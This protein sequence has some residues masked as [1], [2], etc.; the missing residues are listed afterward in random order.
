M[1]A[2]LSTIAIEILI[3][4]HSPLSFQTHQTWW[5]INFFLV[6]LGVILAVHFLLLQLLNIFYG[7]YFCQ[8]MTLF[9][10]WFLWR[11]AGGWTGLCICCSGQLFCADISAAPA[12]LE[13][14]SLPLGNFTFFGLCLRIIWKYHL[15]QGPLKKQLLLSDPRDAYEC[16][17][18]GP[19][20]TL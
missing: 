12:F 8:I 15:A 6:A 2:T 11:A 17:A 18:L 4:Q 20:P 5:E 19:P 3:T 10:C 1:K 7:S 13:E 16:F 9:S 14:T